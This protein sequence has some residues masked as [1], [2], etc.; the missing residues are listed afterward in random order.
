MSVLDARSMTIAS[1]DEEMPPGGLASR[2]PA[3]QPLS[4]TPTYVGVA[5]AVLG[6]VLILIAWQ[7][8]AAETNV[9]LQVPYLVSAG[10]TGLA[11]VMVGVT[12]VNV[13]AKRRDAL[14]REQQTQLLADALQELSAA[15]APDQQ[16]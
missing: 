7:Q 14:L 8:T 12:I 3:L 9:A 16:S 11:T 6:F 10:L 5:V 15:L 1:E 4:P 13:A 2:L